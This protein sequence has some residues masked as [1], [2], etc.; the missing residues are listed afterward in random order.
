MEGV[1]FCNQV[2]STF[3]EVSVG[4]YRG[5]DGA[6]LLQRVASFARICYIYRYVYP[7]I[8]LSIYLSIYIYVYT[9]LYIFLSVQ[10]STIYLSIYLSIHVYI[11][12]SAYSYTYIFPR[13]GESTA[14]V[15]ARPSSRAWLP[16]HANPNTRPA[17]GTSAPAPARAKE[18]SVH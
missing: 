17:F 3:C 15:S 1:T 6:A 9:Y 8:Y 10:L 4:E 11:H 18:C 5:R 2:K 12:I 16:L 14:T 7:S 13:V